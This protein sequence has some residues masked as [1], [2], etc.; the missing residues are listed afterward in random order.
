LTTRESWFQPWLDDSG[1]W[2]PLELDRQERQEIDQLLR[3]ESEA[4]AARLNDLFGQ[5]SETFGADDLAKSLAAVPPDDGNA[6]ALAKAIA[7]LDYY[8]YRAASPRLAVGGLTHPH[9]IRIWESLRPYLVARLQA[10]LSADA[11]QSILWRAVLGRIP[12]SWIPAGLIEKSLARQLAAIAPYASVSVELDLKPQVPG[13]L[14]WVEMHTAATI[15]AIEAALGKRRPS[16]VEL[17][18]APGTPPL[19]AQV[20]VVFAMDRLQAGGPRLLCY[21]PEQDHATIAIVVAVQGGRRHFLE[22][23]PSGDRPPVKAL[24][25]WAMEPEKPPLFGLRRVLD[26]VL[27]WRLAWLV[28]RWLLLRLR[29]R[30]TRREAVGRSGSL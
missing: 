13:G 14:E 19:A 29:V 27:P 4:A 1:P 2:P 30:R 18:R 11:A 20:V 26:G 24:R 15:R 28:R 25:L 3:T 22:S 5:S 7:V 17:I 12:E 6:D 9:N 23:P 21:D 16:L 10:V 8:F